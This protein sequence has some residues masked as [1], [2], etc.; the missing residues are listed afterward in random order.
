M[1]RVV[2]P[3]SSVRVLA[4]GGLGDATRINLPAEV[5]ILSVNAK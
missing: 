4:E 2:G 3:K 5:E 1:Y